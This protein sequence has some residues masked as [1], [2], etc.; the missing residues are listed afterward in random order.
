M[1]IFN[2]VVLSRWFYPV[3]LWY[4]PDVIPAR[5][6]LVILLKQPCSGILADHF[7]TRVWLLT[8][9]FHS[10]C[11]RYNT[12][13]FSLLLV[14]TNVKAFTSSTTAST[15]SNST[16]AITDSTDYKCNNNYIWLQGAN[17]SR[18]FKGT[19]TSSMKSMSN[20]YFRL[21]LRHAQLFQATLRLRTTLISIFSF[22]LSSL[23][24]TFL[25]WF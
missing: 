17:S 6:R 3:S 7:N 20:C 21:T 1:V 16:S 22:E 9:Y 8:F 18:S 24:K 23:T 14:L 11:L 19:T 10:W 5:S 13:N 4:G 12:H 15:S 2:R 25:P